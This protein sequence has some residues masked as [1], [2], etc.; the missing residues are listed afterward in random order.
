M[1]K[2]ATIRDVSERAGV[3]IAV[4]SRVLNPGSGPVAPDTK[5]RVQQAIGELSYRPRT[6][7]RELKSPGTTT[8]GLMLADVANP[9]FA[10]LADK[11]VWEAR[12]R[13]VNVL[14][15]TT[16]EDQHLEEECLNTLYERRVAGVIATPTSTNRAA[17][18]KL[19]DLNTRVVFVD[20]TIE[21]VDFADSVGIDNDLSARRATAH[22]VSLGHTRIGFVSGPTTTSTG[23]ARTEG[24]RQT[25]REHGLD[26]DE[27][28][29]R[30]IPFRGDQGSDAVNALLS[31][32]Q[33]PTA[34]IIANTAQVI[35]S[36]RRL[37]FSGLS[38]P[39]DL[40]V[41]VFDDDPW[42]ELFTPALSIIKQPTEML[43]AHSIELAL[44]TAGERGRTNLLVQA[45]FIERGSTAPPR[46]STPPHD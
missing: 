35:P 38:I 42:T 46:G 8:L 44:N 21:G 36:L 15:M 41:I 40:S 37:A 25:L 32:P 11:I 9:F 12:A 29:I 10:R 39:E 2:P 5:L 43:A 3:S 17:W 20:R 18:E 31:L 7:A 6:A 28:L 23:R 30:H 24:Y 22:L 27:S 26:V 19:D 13:G 33:R 4:V 45:E 16:Q 34:L 14:L 1:A